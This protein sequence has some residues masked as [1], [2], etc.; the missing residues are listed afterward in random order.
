MTVSYVTFPLGQKWKRLLSYRHTGNRLLHCRKRTPSYTYTEL[1][2][3]VT[4]TTRWQCPWI[5]AKASWN[6]NE[7]SDLIAAPRNMRLFL[8]STAG[9]TCFSL[10]MAENA[11]EPHVAWTWFIH[12]FVV[13]GVQPCTALGK[14]HN[15]SV[16]IPP[17]LCSCAFLP[18]ALDFP[19]DID[20]PRNRLRTATTFL[21]QPWKL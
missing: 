21:D 13:T 15:T 17:F 10:R 3:T 1:G 6:P 9:I 5:S 4:L 16:S 18:T 8:I 11:R 12:S 20:H 2:V 7:L 19:L 14:S